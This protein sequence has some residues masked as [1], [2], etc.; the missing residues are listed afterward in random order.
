MIL[1]MICRPMGEPAY[2]AEEQ[3][4]Q[5]DGLTRCVVYLVVS[6]DHL[7]IYLSWCTSRHKPA[8][9]WV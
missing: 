5:G 4:P 2:G 1:A 8:P 6:Q 9:P 7:F 3:S